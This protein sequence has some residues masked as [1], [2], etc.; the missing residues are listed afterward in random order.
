MFQKMPGLRI[1]LFGLRIELLSFSREKWAGLTSHQIFEGEG[2]AYNTM[3]RSADTV[4]PPL[5]DRE[6]WGQAARQFRQPYT[7]RQIV[8]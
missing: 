4:Q 5:R 8:E 6:Q 7:R 1:E 2:V 3:K